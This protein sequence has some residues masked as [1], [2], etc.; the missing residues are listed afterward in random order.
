MKKPKK[1][2][3]SSKDLELMKMFKKLLTPKFKEPVKE[4]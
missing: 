1:L 2:L 3:L 4:N